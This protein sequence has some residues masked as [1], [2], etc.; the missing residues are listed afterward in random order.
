MLNLITDIDTSEGLRSNLIT[1]INTSEGLRSTL[2]ICTDRLEWFGKEI[3]PISPL[4]AKAVSVCLY[5]EGKGAH[6]VE[7]GKLW[8]KVMN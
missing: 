7:Y 4:M 2:Q 3:W 8:M 6:L 1:D 5:V